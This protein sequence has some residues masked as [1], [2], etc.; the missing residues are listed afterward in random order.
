MIRIHGASDDVV[1]I[2]RDGD[3]DEIQAIGGRA[4]FTLNERG[5]LAGLWLRMEYGEMGDYDGG[6]CATVGLNGDGEVIP[7]DVEIGHHPEVS[8]SVRVSI[9]CPAST[10]VEVGE[11]GA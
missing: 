7:W 4:M 2:D 8:Y 10:I 11:V 6:W 5:T 9:D 1:V 3:M